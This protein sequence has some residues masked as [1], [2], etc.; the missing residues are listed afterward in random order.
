MLGEHRRF[1][2]N[3]AQPSI[4][5]SRASHVRNMS[6]AP[7][8]STGHRKTFEEAREERIWRKWRGGDI[9]REIWR[10]LGSSTARLRL[11]APKPGIFFP[12][13]I[14]KNIVVAIG[15]VV[16]RV[17]LLIPFYPSWLVDLPLYSILQ[18]ICAQELQRSEDPKSQ[19]S[20]HDPRMQR[21]WASAVGEIWWLCPTFTFLFFLFKEKYYIW[22]LE[23]DPRFSYIYIYGWRRDLILTSIARRSCL[24]CSRRKVGVWQHKLW[25][26][27][28]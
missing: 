15:K 14:V 22:K 8:C 28:I 18:G 7:H 6:S 13:F 26:E 20:H 1:R 19:A 5:L 10:S 2:Q 27:E 17:S 4:L 9:S 3:R 23:D 11:P 21:S 12:F 25:I 16:V 24:V